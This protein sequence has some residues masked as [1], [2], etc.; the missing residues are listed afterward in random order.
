MNIYDLPI[1]ILQIEADGGSFDF[2]PTHSQ[3]A[4]CLGAF[5]KPLGQMSAR[6]K[7][8]SPGLSC[9]QLSWQPCRKEGFLFLFF[10]FAS[11]CLDSVWGPENPT[12]DRGTGEKPRRVFIT[13]GEV[14]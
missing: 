2:F 14:R 6:P 10:S 7:G 11:S 8:V 3:A 12:E 9:R 1:P 5:N 4:G 13:N